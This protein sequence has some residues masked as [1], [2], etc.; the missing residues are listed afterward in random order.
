M[1]MR[2]FQRKFVWQI[3]SDKVWSYTTTELHHSCSRLVDVSMKT[4]MELMVI[5]LFSADY[6]LI[7]A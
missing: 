2:R 3:L 7:G 1:S 4:R 5:A 6:F